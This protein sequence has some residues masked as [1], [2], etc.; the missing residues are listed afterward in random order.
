MKAADVSLEKREYWRNEKIAFLALSTLKGV[1]FWT[2]YKLA[3]SGVSFKEVLREPEGKLIDKF[4]DFDE[5][6]ASI[7]A[8]Q[9]TLW[10]KG[11]VL[12]RSLYSE[13]IRLIFKEEVGFPPKLKSIPDAPYWIFV[14]GD[15]GALFCKS[16]AIVGTRQPSE[17]GVFLSKLVLAALVK[18]KCVTVSGLAMGVDQLAHLG[19]IRYGLKTIA[20]LG[21]GI[22]GNYPKGSEGLRRKILDG[23]GC[24][25]SEYLPHQSYSAENFI[26]RNRLQAA[27]CDLLIPVEWGVKS[28]TAHTVRFAAKYEKVILNLY[29]PLTYEL[30]PELEFSEQQ[31][32]AASIEMPAEIPQFEDFIYRYVSEDLFFDSGNISDDVGSDDFEVFEK[33]NLDGESDCSESDEILIVLDETKDEFASPDG[34]TSSSLAERIGSNENINVDVDVKAQREGKDEE[35]K[36]F[37]LKI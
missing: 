31:Y 36:Q 28:G 30:K 19:S 25:I 10:Q 33:A 5:G 22:L 1:G 14:Q 2:L 32:G 12:A 11:L 9:D 27:L 7:V 3:K 18:F 35:G 15:V 6:A 21:T 26:R 8:Q 4:Y 17:D 13:N 16:V 20:V 34:G 29:L 24:V 23:G 37:K